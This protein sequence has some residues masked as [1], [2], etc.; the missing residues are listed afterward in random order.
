MNNL[1][2]YKKMNIILKARLDEINFNNM[3]NNFEKNKIKEKQEQN[4]INIKENN[5]QYY[6]IKKINENNLDDLDALYF[7]DKIDMKPQRSYSTGKVIP[8]LPIINI[9]K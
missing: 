2:E 3:K 7:W 8:Y 5:E 6:K 9:N 1:D 4:I